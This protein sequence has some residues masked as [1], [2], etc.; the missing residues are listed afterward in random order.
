M[1]SFMVGSYLNKRAYAVS[2]RPEKLPVRAVMTSNSYRGTPESGGDLT[3]ASEKALPVVVCVK[4]SSQQY[5]QTF[6]FWFGRP[7]ETPYQQYESGSGV[8]ISDNGF[9]VTNNHVIQN[10]DNIEVVLNDKRTYTAKVIGTDPSSDIAILK[11]EEKDLPFVNYANSDD[12]KVGEWVLAVGNPYNLTSTVTAGIISAK[13][14]NLT[15]DFSIESFIQTDAVVNP[16]NSGGALV[17]S[18]GDLIG[19]TTQIVTQTGA[20]IGYSFAIPSNIVHKVA[21]DIIKY[22]EVQRAYL[23]LSIED[24]DPKR[25]G[26]MG[27][28]PEGVYVTKITE[29]GGASES[30]LKKGDVIVGIGSISIRD[31]VGLQIQL[32]KY[33]PGD[34]VDVAIIRD[35]KNMVLPVM[36]KNIYGNTKIIKTE[37]SNAYG[38]T[39]QDLEPSEKQGLHVKLLIISR[40]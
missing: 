20:Y 21:D 27:I 8:I 37:I 26:E 25:A 12:I 30:G 40:F 23:G 3:V 34:K 39:F 5:I 29:G 33:H 38:A 16:G 35:K 4:S 10:S 11:I 13:P 36:L 22:G 28:N 7:K 1:I 9:I 32:S 6:D 17:N 15:S 14:R 18:N 19:I 31:N 2:G 24:L